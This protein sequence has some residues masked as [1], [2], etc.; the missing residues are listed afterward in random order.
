V[1]EANA[2]RG[3]SLAS[4]QSSASEIS[5][6]T[7]SP[8][9]EKVAE[10]AHPGEG[11]FAPAIPTPTVVVVRDTPPVPRMTDEELLAALAEAGHPSGL[12][13]V[14]GHTTIVANTFADDDAPSPLVPLFTGFE[15]HP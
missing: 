12:I 6:G 14:N 8:P 7:L 9:E 10:S 5:S 11:V 2:G 4:S 3:A 15:T 1:S 13:T